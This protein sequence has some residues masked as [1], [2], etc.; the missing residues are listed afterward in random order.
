MKNSTK[1]K[2]QRDYTQYL[3]KGGQ[4][5]KGTLVLAVVKS[6]VE[7]HPKI[8]IDKLKSIFLKKEMHSGF[9]IV[10]PV[11][12]AAKGRFFLNKEDIIKTTDTKIA[13]TSQ[14]DKKNI[15]IFI[16]FVKK[17]LNM[18]IKTI[19]DSSYEHIKMIA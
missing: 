4:Y 16:L 17:N 18:K 10:E 11:R 6:Y 19:H 8:T 13:V 15:E 9:E 12:K 14:W 3:F 7:K 2:T 1:S 5:G